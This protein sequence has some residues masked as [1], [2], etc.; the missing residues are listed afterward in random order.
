MLEILKKS[1]ETGNR[2]TARGSVFSLGLGIG[3]SLKCFQSKFI[4][5]RY[6]KHS[7]LK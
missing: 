3:Y 5:L 1:S 6:L 4:V 7:C 2:F